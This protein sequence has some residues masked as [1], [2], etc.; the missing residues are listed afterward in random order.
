[1]SSRV[2]RPSSARRLCPSRMWPSRRLRIDQR[3]EGS[4][5]LMP[6]RLP[7]GS[8]RYTQAVADVSLAERLR[9]ALDLA[10][11]GISMMRQ[12]LHRAHP[13]ASAE[14]IEELLRDWISYRPGAEWGDCPGPLRR[15]P[16]V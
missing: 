13:E 6:S 14:D 2:F 8:D 12:N 15:L 9:I 1:M 4:I 16:D 5:G 7:R 10:D 3:R 11:A